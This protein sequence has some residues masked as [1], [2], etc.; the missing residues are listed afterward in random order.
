MAPSVPTPNRPS[1]KYAAY[2]VLLGA[3]I[4]SFSGVYVQWV[5]LGP[6]ASG[7]YRVFIGGI[8]LTLMALFRR[9]RWWSRPK[10]LGM[11]LLCGFIFALDLFVWHRSVIFV[12]PGLATILGNFQVFLLA[13]IGVTILK[14]RMT[15]RL[16]AAIPV[17]VLGLFLVVG[18]Q[19]KAL[20][21]DYRWGVFFG[22]ATALCYAGYILTLRWL[23]T[24]L[25][26][27]AAVPNLAVVSL[28]TAVVLG[29]LSLWEGETLVISDG[30]TMTALAAY[31]LFSQVLG[32]ML[33]SK[34]LPGVRASLAG[35]LLLMQ[36][37][38][39]FVWDMVF[40]DMELTVSKGIG[41][42]MTLVA[43]YLGSTGRSEE[44]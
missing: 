44:R 21:P 30:R 7:F 31:G 42:V 2:G 20:T 28:T 9:S 27:V 16:I 40:F 43:I 36:P 15:F 41:T 17:A 10:Y 35:L 14:E 13:L 22:L 19:W 12:G 8:C 25:H 24:D 26:R 34:G 4:I 39:A 29:L 5:N 23:Q 32:W 33:I 37:T 18:I 1:E 6:T 3:V 11:Q 38:L